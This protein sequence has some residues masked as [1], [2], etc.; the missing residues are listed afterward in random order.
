MELHVQRLRDMEEER[1]ERI[2]AQYRRIR[3]E[4]TD[5]LRALPRG[6]FSAQQLRGVLV[7]VESAVEAMDD[8]LLNQMRSAVLDLVG[9]GV[10]DLV[11]EIERFDEEFLDAV[12]PIDV[13]LLDVASDTAELL[14]NQHEASLQSYSS[15]IRAS[16]GR[17]LTDG[18]I[19]GR[20]VD[21]VLQRMGD[22]FFGEEWK[23]RRIART[24]L[25]NAHGMA[26]LRSLQRLDEAQGGWMKRLYHPLDSRTADDSKALLAQ[27]PVIPINE[28]FR[29]TWRGATR[30]FMS[31][32]D[33]PNDRSVLLPFRTSWGE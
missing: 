13:D 9:L 29:F 22:F 26:K 23:L 30:I 28:P 31:P 7:Q 19:E 5:R 17:Y 4:L 2:V 16:V 11:E 33:R 12:Q 24:E 27:D 3:G 14:L 15:S 1:S 8:G 10:D 21:V 6:S 20:P 32:P 18:A 25:H